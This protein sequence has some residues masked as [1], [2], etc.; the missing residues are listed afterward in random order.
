M[1]IAA[2]A[3]TNEEGA[4]VKDDGPMREIIF[5][6]GD[7]LEG[8]VLKPNGVDVGGAVAK[9]HASMIGIRG[10]FR[11]KLIFLSFDI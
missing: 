9:A 4:T 5:E 8:E 1:A 2:P 10:Q 6:V 11:D 7:E 3:S